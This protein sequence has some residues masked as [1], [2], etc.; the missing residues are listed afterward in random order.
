MNRYILNTRSLF[1]LYLIV[2][3]MLLL[4]TPVDVFSQS[5]KDP[6]CRYRSL[7]SGKIVKYRCDRFQSKGD[8]DS[9]T[10]QIKI[11]SPIDGDE[12]DYSTLTDSND[13]GSV[14][15]PI[16]V[17]VSPDSDYT[18][19][20][21]AASSAATEYLFLPQIDGLGHVHAYIAPEIEVTQDEEGNVTGVNFVESDN[22]ADQVGGFCVFR[23]PVE[24]TDTYQVLTANCELFQSVLPIENNSTHRVIVDTT[25]NSHG[26]R[27]KHHPRA[28]PPGDKVVITFV[29][30]P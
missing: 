26:P 1:P 5:K 14:E 8:T 2:I 28:V 12:I 18:V 23:E 29:N 3:A 22:R 27:L 11:I 17:V 9:V 19:D 30:V 13:N 24:Q 10:P 7:V 16:T 21:T 25:E 15:L 20:F 4:I 6:K